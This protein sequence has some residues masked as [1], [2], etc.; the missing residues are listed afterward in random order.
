MIKRLFKFLKGV[1]LEDVSTGEP[2]PC[3]WYEECGKAGVYGGHLNKDSP[4][5]V[6]ACK[7]HAGRLK[8]L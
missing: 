1:R 8:S 4:D 6:V 3:Y 7:K 2:H 5:L